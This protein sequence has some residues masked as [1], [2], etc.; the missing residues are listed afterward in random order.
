[1]ITH[2]GY[3]YETNIYH[4]CLVDEAVDPFYQ[5]YNIITVVAVKDNI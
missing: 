2:L 1:M 5:N 4:R 3:T